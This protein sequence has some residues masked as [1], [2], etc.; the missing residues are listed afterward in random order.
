MNVITKRFVT[1]VKAN[2]VK[3]SLIAKELGMTV[4]RLKKM[5]IN[6]EPFTYTESQELLAIFVAELMA[7]LIDWRV[8][9]ACR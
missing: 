9:Y 5:L 8:V 4:E 3:L 2:G 6:R 1:M 7:M